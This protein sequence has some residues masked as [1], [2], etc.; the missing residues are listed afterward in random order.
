MYFFYK[1]VRVF[2]KRA[3]EP[4]AVF[5][6]GWGG[7]SQSFSGAEN[8][9]NSLGV[10]YVAPDLPGFGKSGYDVEWDIFDYADCVSALIKQMGAVTLV[11][12]SF[13]GRIAL[14]LGNQKSIEKIVLTGCAGLKPRFSLSKVVSE[15]KYK[16][17]KKLKRDLS[18]FG[19]YDYRNAG[20][21][22]P[23]LVRVVNEYLDKQA[24]SVTA[25]TL[26]VW[27]KKDE[28][29]PY[30]MAKSLARKIKGSIL[31]PLDGDHFAY[32]SPKFSFYLGE[33]IK[34]GTICP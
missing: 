4:K 33:F 9:L 27:G 31:K 8:Y 2:Y 25:K 19:S 16:L 32:L 6:H 20:K 34:G 11:G 21:L 3:G 10:G 30:Y 5:L 23:V 1:G 12:H 13:G 22:K 29:T 26:I 14:I 15:T 18:R 17:Y 24:K 28:V 7:D